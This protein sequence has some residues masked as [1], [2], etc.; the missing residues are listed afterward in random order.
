LCTACCGRI[1]P[2]LVNHPLLANEPTG[3]LNSQTGEEIVAL[4]AKGHQSGNTLYLVTHEADIAAHTFRVIRPREG[5]NEK[6]LKRLC[7][8]LR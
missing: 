7:F 6:P 3:N 1:A 2:G 8:R 4:F 5:E